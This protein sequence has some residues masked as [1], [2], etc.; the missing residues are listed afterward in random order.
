[1]PTT[2]KLLLYTT[3]ASVILFGFCVI[4]DAASSST[5]RNQTPA[6]RST[7]LGGGEHGGATETT[8]GPTAIRSLRGM[9]ARGS[10]RLRR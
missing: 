5:S 9:C 4:P 6:I 2:L 8:G 1:M 7:A 10:G 3:A